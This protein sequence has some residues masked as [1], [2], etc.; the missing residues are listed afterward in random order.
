MWSRLL[1]ACSLAACHTTFGLIEVPP[2]GD[3]GTDSDIPLCWDPQA[4]DNED[5]DAFADGCDPCPADGTTE[6]VADADGD[7]VG[8]VC[9]PG[10]GP[11]DVI[12]EFDG[13]V[14]DR[15]WSPVA[16]TWQL[17]NGFFTASPGALSIAE[18]APAVV[19]RP[20]LDLVFTS[21]G[22]VGAR[23]YV[24]ALAIEVACTCEP[25]SSPTPDYVQLVVNS[26]VTRE[27]LDRGG[28][29]RMQL[30]L[31]GAGGVFCHVERGG[32]AATAT[33]T[34]PTMGTTTNRIALVSNGDSSFNSVTLF[35]QR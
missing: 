32:L 23:I 10:A 20:V 11:G 31:D 5:S 4:T 7:R 12:R 25:G 16:G 1:L 29:G 6:P 28:A 26:V 35:G 27:P 13:F 34:E 21:T 3:S 17:A 24:G 15:A 19:E 8:D 18:A 33:S 9:D 2:V 14:R 22:S 30:G